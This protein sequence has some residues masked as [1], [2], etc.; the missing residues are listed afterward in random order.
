MGDFMIQICGEEQRM[1]YE[2]VPIEY[3]DKI[4]LILRRARANQ[5][6]TMRALAGAIGVG[7]STV[8]AWEAGRTSPSWQHLRD[9]ALILGYNIRVTVEMF[10]VSETGEPS[11]LTVSNLPDIKQVFTNK[12]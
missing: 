8:F 3:M 11:V 1:T 7:D 10:E 2:S 12:A 6:V 5:E 4:R 9:W